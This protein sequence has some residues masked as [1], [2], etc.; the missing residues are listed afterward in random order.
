[1]TKVK[2]KKNGEILQRPDKMLLL[3]DSLP[4]FLLAKDSSIIYFLRI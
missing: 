2:K 4:Q 1:M 3:G